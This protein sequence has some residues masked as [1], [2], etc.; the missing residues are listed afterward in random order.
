M[1]TGMVITGIMITGMVTTA[2]VTMIMGLGGLT[3]VAMVITMIG[4]IMD[5]GGLTVL[6][7]VLVG[8]RVTE[9][10]PPQAMGITLI[11]TSATPPATAGIHAHIIMGIRAS[12]ARVGK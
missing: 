7:V 10:M 6:A 11:P 4:M 5:P 12:A 2:M 9:R 3:V 1:A 8:T